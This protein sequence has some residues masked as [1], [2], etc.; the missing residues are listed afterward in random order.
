MTTDRRELAYQQALRYAEELAQLVGR[1]RHAAREVGELREKREAVEER[2]RAGM[3][4]VYQ[5]IVDLRDDA[6]AGLEA[7]ARFDGDPPKGPDVWFRDAAQVGLATELELAAINR[8]L[9][10]FDEL[11]ADA[12]LSLNISPA[13]AMS[14]QFF[15][16]IEGRDTARLVIEVT[17]HAQVGDYARLADR[18][19]S[20]RAGGGR[21]AVDDAGAGFASLHHILALGPD[22]IKLDISL[23]RNIDSDGARR[24]LATAMISFAVEIGAS[25]VAEG[26][27]TEAECETLKEL[28][29]SHGQGYFLGRPAP[30]VFRPDPLRLT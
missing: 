9:E 20:F 28:G 13:S 8:A 10:P 14:S 19:K 30:W 5:P 7:L 12:F 3:R 2:L 26:I 25:M 24:A 4:I 15:Q 23:T 17:E 22:I 29:V 11:P 1:E 18:L 27:E 21:L 6:V 16:A